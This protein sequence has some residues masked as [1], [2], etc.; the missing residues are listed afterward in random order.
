MRSEKLSYANSA[1]NGRLISAETFRAREEAGG[2]GDRDGIVV[3]VVV[4][5]LAADVLEEATRDAF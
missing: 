4:V 3:V 2:R 5:E 1:R